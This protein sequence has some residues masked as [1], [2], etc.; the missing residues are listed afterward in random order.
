LRI[1]AYLQRYQMVFLV[2][3]RVAREVLIGELLLL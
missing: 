1:P 2:V 3:R